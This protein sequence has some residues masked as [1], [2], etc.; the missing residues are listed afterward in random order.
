MKILHPDP[1]LPQ[2]RGNILRHPLGQRGHQHPL[3]GFSRLIDFPDQILDLSIR[4]PNLHHGIQ[5][6]GRPD[7]LLRHHS[8]HPDLIP[9]RG[10]RHKQR[11]PTHLPEFLRLE[12]PVVH[13]TGQAEPVLHKLLLP[14]PVPEIHSLKLRNRNM[15]LIH[16]EHEILRKEIDQAP[17]PLPRTAA[18][19]V[20]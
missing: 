17:R 4:R 5:Q 15:A 18:R 19:Q 11:L 6:T 2:K 20:P 12:R 10:R 16:K 8:R 14:G 3:P 9:G 1:C 13:R 7:H